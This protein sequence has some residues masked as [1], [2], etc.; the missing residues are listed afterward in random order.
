MSRGLVKVWECFTLHVCSLQ[1][2]PVILP[3]ELQEWQVQFI[4]LLE[5]YI[6]V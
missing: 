1:I 6:E 3:A 5:Q 2:K 4:C